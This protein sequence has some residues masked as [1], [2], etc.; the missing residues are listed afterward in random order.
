MAWRVP[1]TFATGLKGPANSDF[2]EKMLRR[3]G[4]SGISDWNPAEG[5]SR[6]VPLEVPYHPRTSKVLTRMYDR[7]SH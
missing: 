6:L 2:A 4:T 1:P 7:C 5:S 3:A